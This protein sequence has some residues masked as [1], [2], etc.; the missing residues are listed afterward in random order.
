MR[1]EPVRAGRPRR[2]RDGGRPRT[3]RLAAALLTCTLGIAGCGTS[4]SESRPDTA[5]PSHRAAETSTASPGTPGGEVSALPAPDAPVPSDPARL[6]GTLARTTGALYDAVDAWRDDGN[7]ARGKPPEAV[8]LLALHEQRI[9]R[10]L[11]RRPELARR[12]VAR[13]PGA[14]AARAGDNVPAARALFSLAEPVGD[15]SS[16]RTQDPQPAGVLLR[17]F[18]RA[19]RRYDVEWQVLAAVMFVETKFGRVTSPSS[20]GAQGP[21]QFMPATW[22]AYGIGGDVHDPRDAV[23][24][25]ANYLRDSGAPGDYERALHAYNPAREYVDAVLRHARQMKRDPRNYYA[26]YSWQVFVLTE[27]GDVRITGPQPRPRR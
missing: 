13:L 22:D 19:E 10:H 1:P 26:Y 5:A 8:V 23:L 27:R 14:L 12:T 4:G 11:A 18:Q 6:A 3:A 20:A 2:P 25:A 24:G 21:M 17:Y 7:P 16:F 9:Y 15:A